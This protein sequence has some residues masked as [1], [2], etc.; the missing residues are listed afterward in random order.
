MLSPAG[1]R[2]RL[3][4][5]SS[6]VSQSISPTD[7]ENETFCHTKGYVIINLIMPLLFHFSD[8]PCSEEA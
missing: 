6:E 5:R 7:F 4:L 8:C 2:L 3:R 1:E